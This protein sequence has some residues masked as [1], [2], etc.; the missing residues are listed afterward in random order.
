VKGLQGESCTD[1][2]ARAGLLCQIEEESWPVSR[3]DIDRLVG[4]FNQTCETYVST[5]QTFDPSVSGTF[6]SHGPWKPTCI[7]GDKFIARQ[8]N[9][10]SCEAIPPAATARLCPCAEH[11]RPLSCSQC[12]PNC[13]RNKSC[14]PA[15]LDKCAGDPEKGDDPKY[16]GSSLSKPATGVPPDAWCQQ[17]HPQ[18]W[19]MP[20]IWPYTGSEA[21]VA[22]DNTTI[23]VRLKVL[24]YNL[25]W[26]SLYGVRKGNAEWPYGPGSASVLIADASKSEPFDVMGFQECKDPERVLSEAGLLGNYTFYHGP[27]D[28]CVAFRNATWSL[29]GSGHSEVAEDG[30]FVRKNY[31]SKRTG[32]WLRLRHKASGRV[33]FF[34]NHHGP[35]PLHSGGLCG[36]L[37]TA[38]N[39]LQ[40]IS[41]NMESTDAVV[42]VGDFNANSHSMTVRS[43]KSELNLLY[44]GIAFGGV[45][46]FFANVEEEHV[47]E[48]HNYGHGGSDH[49]ALGLVMELTTTMTNMTVLDRVVR[50]L[51][52]A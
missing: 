2:C 5:E 52:T 13:W 41:N 15:I 48:R 37:A 25:Y 44:E 30:D 1:A 49:H 11:R 36:G 9:F 7:W 21:T 6:C 34:V 17:G 8:Q 28:T 27:H 32:Q 38:Y 4:A 18:E 40:L 43:M 3:F 39:L 50:W 45:D 33:L 47:L 20:K 16:W 35:L 26:W 46:N 19:R 12:D 31:W 22:P 29:L 42:L 14:C 23:D 24:S 51:N 10:R